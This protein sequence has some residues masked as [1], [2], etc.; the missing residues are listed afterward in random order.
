MREGEF[1]TFG[2][3]AQIDLH[4]RLAG[5]LGTAC[6]APAHFQPLG[7]YHLEIFAAALVLGAIKHAEANLKAATDTRIR[8]DQQHG[9][10]IGPPPPNDALLR[11]ERI[12]HDRRSSPDPA[13]NSEARHHPLFLASASLAS[14]QA[15]S[16]SRL[17]HQKRSYRRSQ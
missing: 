16:R 13:H 11:G 5:I 7:T 10:G 12:E 14:V 4:E 15:A 6:P 9:A 17:P 3:G 2:D 1:G 8:L